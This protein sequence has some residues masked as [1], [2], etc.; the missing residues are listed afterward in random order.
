[1]AKH[2]RK[3]PSVLPEFKAGKLLFGKSNSDHMIS[4]DWERATG[5]G[6]P[7]LIPFEDL[8]L[9]PFSSALHYGIQCFEGLKDYRN[10]K[11]EIR[12][13]RP[14][15]N[16]LRLKRSSLRLTL[17]DFDGHELIKLIE[18]LLKVEERWIPPTTEFSLYVRPL[19]FATDNALGVHS[20]DRSKLL[21]MTG[22]VGP[23]YPTGFKP[24]SLYCATQ[25]I[26]SAPKGTG[27]YKIGGYC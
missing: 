10:N 22:P 17:P 27:A 16:M 19:H 1:L 12:L 26:R 25:T 8:Q 20:P 5:W 15:C 13:F 23:Y 3:A 7:S 4:V 24:I 9:H 14:W 6:N 11:E 18:E 21:V 2:L